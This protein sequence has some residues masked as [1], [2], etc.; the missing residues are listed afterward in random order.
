LAAS[1]SI[2]TSLAASASLASVASVAAVA[3]VAASD[4][5]KRTNVKGHEYLLLFLLVIDGLYSNLITM[6]QG[7][8]LKPEN[9]NPIREM[10]VEK[11]SYYSIFVLLFWKW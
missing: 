3:A 11:K 4:K 1:A 7:I 6:V 2:A 8:D 10:K 5:R 9:L